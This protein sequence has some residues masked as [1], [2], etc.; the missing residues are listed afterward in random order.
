MVLDHLN[1]G[2]GMFGRCFWEF[3][4]NYFIIRGADLIKADDNETISNISSGGRV[5]DEKL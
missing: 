4:G 5:S 2:V 3:K 1:Y